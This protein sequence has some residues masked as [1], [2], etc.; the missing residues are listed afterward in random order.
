MEEW[1]ISNEA[2]QTHMYMAPLSRGIQLGIHT[3]KSIEVTCCHVSIGQENVCLCCWLGSDGL[4]MVFLCSWTKTLLTCYDHNVSKN[5][6]FFNRNTYTWH[7][8]DRIVKSDS[9]Q[10]DQHDWIGPTWSVPFLF[11][12]LVLFAHR[13]IIF[14][15]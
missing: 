15:V 11:R 10:V 8:D 12:E 5:M 2:N 1:T 6:V 14:H 4:K 7:I 9:L 13:I 3:I